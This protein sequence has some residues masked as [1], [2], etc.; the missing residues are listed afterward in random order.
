MFCSKCGNEIRADV[1]FCPICGTQVKAAETNIDDEWFYIRENMRYGPCQYDTMYSLVQNGQINK[2]TL[3][4]KKG[5]VNWIPAYQTELIQ[6][7][8]DNVPPLPNEIVSNKFAWALATVPILVSWIVQLIGF[9]SVVVIICT[10]ALNIVFLMLDSD[11]LNK[12]GLNANS[13]LW[14]GVVFV[15][16]YLFMRSSKTDKKYGY[17]ITWCVMFLLDLIL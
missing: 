13:W 11:E 8:K 15:P 10:I 16:V 14:M 17:A 5:M 12:F 2:D 9:P 1:K 7:I 4:W 6:I 3:V